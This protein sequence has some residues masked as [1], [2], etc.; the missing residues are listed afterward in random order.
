MIGIEM[1]KLCLVTWVWTST[2]SSDVVLEGHQGLVSLEE[3]VNQASVL[4]GRQ[5]WPLF[6]SKSWH[7]DSYTAANY[8]RKTWEHFSHYLLSRWNISGILYVIS[9]LCFI[10]CSCSEMKSVSFWMFGTVQLIYEDCDLLALPV[11]YYFLFISV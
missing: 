8:T 3:R 9:R 10:W 6:S 5:W 1:M 4:E 2:S 7:I 11:Q